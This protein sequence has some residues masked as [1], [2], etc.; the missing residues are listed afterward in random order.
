[1]L[2]L[3]VYCLKKALRLKVSNLLLIFKFQN[4]TSDIFLHFCNIL[5]EENFNH[6]LI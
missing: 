2:S 3:L 6:H 1:M 4:K 5:A